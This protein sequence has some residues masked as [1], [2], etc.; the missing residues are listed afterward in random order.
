[1]IIFTVIKTSEKELN[2]EFLWREP[3]HSYGSI[4]NPA[5]SVGDIVGLWYGHSIPSDGK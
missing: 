4:S 1:M 2:H 5:T 3:G